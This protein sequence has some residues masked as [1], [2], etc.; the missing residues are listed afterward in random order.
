MKQ[1]QDIAATF[2][3]V[4]IIHQ[5]IRHHSVKLHQHDDH[6]IF[7]PLQGE[8]QI[9]TKEGILKAGP[10][11]MIYLPPETPHSFTSNSSQEGERLIVIIENTIWKKT[12]A[13]THDATLTSV[14]QLCKELLFHL[15]IHPKTKAAQPL[16]S[17]LILT[18]SEMLESA[19][20]QNKGGADH[21]VANDPRVAKALELIQKTF[22]SS[23]KIEKLS[24]ESGL[25]T[26]NLNRLFLEELGMTPKQVITL[27][28]INQAKR[29]L[30]ERG[31][32]VTDVAYS[33][34]YQSVSQFITTFRAVT[35][36]LPTSQKMKGAH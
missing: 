2:N 18:I 32:T 14:S 33:V 34:G 4:T 27:H 5:K 24:R 28:R 3:G 16:L 31:A 20:L 23:L 25:S 36:Q 1:G 8:I 26:R 17:T 29:L 22:S 9:E 6:E 30:R 7:L 21:L 10:G 15:L 12:G 11:K 19:P 35:G 13:G